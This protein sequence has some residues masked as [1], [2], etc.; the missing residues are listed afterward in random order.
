MTSSTP[1]GV[2]TAILPSPMSAFVRITDSSR[3][4]RHVRKVPNSGSGKPFERFV[5]LIHQTR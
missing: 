5:P 2:M 1:S 3:T 4:S